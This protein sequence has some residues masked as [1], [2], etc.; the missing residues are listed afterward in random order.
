M[1]KKDFNGISIRGRVVF[2]I[3]CFENYV[4]AKYPARQFD[5]VCAL[6]WDIVSDKDYIDASAEKYMEIIPE[7]LY[8]FDS[9]EDAG[10]EYLTRDE[11]DFFSELI[12]SDD[13]SLS[14]IM[15]RIYDIAMEHAYA[16]VDYPAKAS[17]DLLF[18]IIDAL[19]REGIKLPDIGL[20]RGFAFAESGGWGNPVS[21]KGLSR[22][23]S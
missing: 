8:E 2:A 4:I 17:I 18:E 1:N 9:Y 12:P 10:F 22:I 16:A 21:R 5:G 6:M 13:E 14:L 23:L 19:K 15:H 7:Y 20:V 11:F 3:M